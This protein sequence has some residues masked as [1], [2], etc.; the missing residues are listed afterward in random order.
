MDFNCLFVVIGF[1]CLFLFTVFVQ[2]SIIMVPVSTMISSLFLIMLA[3]LGCMVHALCQQSPAHTSFG[4]QARSESP[5]KR[6][7]LENVSV[8]VVS[9]VISYL[10]VLVMAPIFYSAQ[11]WSIMDIKN[12][13]CVIGE[14]Y[15]IFPRLGVFMG[16]LFYF[17]RVR[18]MCCHQGT[19]KTFNE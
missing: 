8:V 11:S 17:S 1:C 6:K 2:I 3:C 14:A 9:A 7:T 10:P 13:L 19:G 18:Q 15:V 5:L 16:P 4:K 12:I